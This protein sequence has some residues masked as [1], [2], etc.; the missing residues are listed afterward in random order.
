MKRIST[1][2]TS[3]LLSIFFILVGFFSCYSTS[4]A[5]PK[6]LR[7][8]EWI[9]VPVSEYLDELMATIGYISTELGA[10]ASND[11]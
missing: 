3:F 4:Y 11:L 8:G 5:L 1:R 9:D 7:T 10:I 2:I 6:R